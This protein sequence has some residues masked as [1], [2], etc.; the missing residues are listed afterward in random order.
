VGLGPRLGFATPDGSFL[1]RWKEEK[2]APGNEKT[3][4]PGMQEGQDDLV[5]S[6]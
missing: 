6:R 4:V 3:K 2:H 5:T 1:R